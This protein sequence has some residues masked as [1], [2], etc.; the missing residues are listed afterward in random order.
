MMAVYSRISSGARSFLQYSQEQRRWKI[1]PEC[2]DN[3]FPS[4]QNS[5]RRL[6]QPCVGIKS[7]GN[8]VL[9]LGLGQMAPV[10][11][12]SIPRVIRALRLNPKGKAWAGY[13]SY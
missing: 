8:V 11:V 7:N 1:K 10:K 2:P 3:K 12:W 4:F 6:K 13:P 5:F 9:L